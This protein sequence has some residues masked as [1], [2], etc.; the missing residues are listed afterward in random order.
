VTRFRTFR[1]GDPPGLLRI[2]NEAFSG[3]GSVPLRSTSL[4]EYFLLAK[5]YFDPA[6]LLVA[7]D[8]GDLVG[9]GLCG[10]APNATGT[11]LDFGSGILCLLGVL[12]SHRHRGIGTELLR[13]CEAYLRQRGAKVLLAGP[14]A[15]NNPFTFGIYGGSQS[16][17]FLDS[18]GAGPFFERR[19][20]RAAE[21]TLVMQRHLDRPFNVIDGRFP[22]LRKRF[23]V[24]QLQR[25]GTG[26]WYVEGVRGP[27]EVEAF[28]VEERGTNHVAGQVLVWEM[29]PYSQR[30]NEHAV[31]V[32]HVR[33]EEPFRRQGAARLLLGNVLRF[34]HDQ[35]FTL[36]E[37][38]VPAV[39]T[40][41]LGLFRGLGFQQI[42]TGRVYR[43]HGGQN[44]EMSVTAILPPKQTSTSAPAT[45]RRRW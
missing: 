10:F 30:W 28:R 36:V 43:R 17:G 2:W 13:L 1:N 20:Y 32:L 4:L 22:A 26:S 37:A 44:S 41:A 15:P 8:D 33:I 12:P 42:D 21:T 6:G 38:Q 45:R 14:R 35:Y 34:Y 29:E 18:D 19:G 40:G 25:R 7:E 11:A 3:R 23:E 9:C 5:P 31:G 16:P 39:D 27:L 24:R